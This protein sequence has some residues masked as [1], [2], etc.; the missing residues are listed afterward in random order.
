M[1]EIPTNGHDHELEC[2]VGQTLLTTNEAAFQS[3]QDADAALCGH[4]EEEVSH[5][6]AEVMANNP[7]ALIDGSLGSIG[8]QTKS[9]F[10]DTQREDA[11]A[12]DIETVKANLNVEI[13]RASS[14]IVHLLNEVYAHLSHEYNRAVILEQKDNT[15]ILVQAQAPD[16]H[17][18]SAKKFQEG[19][20]FL[21][22]SL[23]QRSGF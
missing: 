5:M 3:Q 17:D 19:L 12:Y 23:N 22:R 16:W 21:R 13:D 1:Q 18:R 15:D 7:N 10:T 4:T 8:E 2:D 14:A 6:F 20:M 11:E 9:I